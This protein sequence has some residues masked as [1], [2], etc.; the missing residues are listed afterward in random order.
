[1][2]EFSNSNNNNKNQPP[3][4]PRWV[5]ISGVIAMVLVL[6]V[7]I[8]MFLSGGNHGPGRHFPGGAPAEEVNQES[9]GKQVPFDNRNNPGEGSH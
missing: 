1:M 6:L 8:I 9:A 7:L 5:K 3:R 2:S 4:T